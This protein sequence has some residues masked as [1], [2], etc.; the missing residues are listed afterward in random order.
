MVRSGHHIV[1]HG[2]RFFRNSVDDVIDADGLRDV[3]NEKQQQANADYRQHHCS[4]HGGHWS[5]GVREG[6]CRRK[7]R[8]AVRE[9]AEEDTE[10]PLRHAVP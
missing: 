7:R 10:C 1:D 6:A 2:Y 8:H 5:E 4:Q 3:V 9:G